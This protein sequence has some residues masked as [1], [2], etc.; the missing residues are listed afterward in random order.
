MRFDRRLGALPVALLVLTSLL[1]P[2][3]ASAQQAISL[4]T[5]YPSVSVQPGASVSFELTVGAEEAG[6]VA[7]ALEGVPEGWTA[8][9]R[10]GGFEVQAA[11]ATPDT[12]ATVTVDVQVP[13]D[14]TEGTVP[15]IVR[16]TAGDA[17]AELPLELN[18][19]AA[20]GGTVEMAADFPALR[21]TAEQTFEFSLELSNDTPQALTFSLQATGP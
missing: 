8:T 3:A 9:M 17:T 21:G 1:A 20:A 12:P 18:V 7:L 10:G 4:T 13:D 15:I 6:R 16:G 14:A 19:L 2:P 11:Y 5:P